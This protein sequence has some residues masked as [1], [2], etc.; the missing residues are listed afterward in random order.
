M[1]ALDT[2]A[3]PSDVAP[4][5]SIDLSI[6]LL[7]PSTPGTYKGIWSFE[8]NTGQK[9]GLGVSGNGQVWVQ[10]RVISPANTPTVLSASTQTSE[11]TI[12][13]TIEPTMSISANESLVYDF[14]SEICAAQWLNNNVQQPCP[15]TGSE[16]QNVTLVTMPTLEDG[17]TLIA[18]A[19]MVGPGKPNE[20]IQGTYPEYLVQSGDHFRAMVGCDVNSIS[21][22]AILRVSYED[23]S[24]TV[25]NLSAVGE[26]YDQKYTQIDIDLGN[27]A[28]QKIKIILDVTPLNS[29]PGNHVLWVLPGIYREPLPTATPTL[30]PTITATVAPIPTA[31]ATLM[32]SPI[33]API[34]QPEPQSLMEQIQDFFNS[35]FKN[36]FGD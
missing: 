28:G 8:D 29:D 17:S 34:S 33:P 23:S 6:N 27:L 4:G 5:Q 22:S 15:G 20:S 11:P 2:M 3:L 36:I 26:F 21:C 30:V 7:A 14:A 9:F 25:I 13:A 35:I 1:D 16:A 10:V 12:V 18:P 32:P 31:T 19:I 24:N